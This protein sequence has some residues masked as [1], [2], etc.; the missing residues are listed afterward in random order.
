MFLHKGLEIHER[1]D[2]GVVILE[3][4]GKL[5]MGDGAEAL[6]E[7]AGGLFEQGKR[8]IALDLAKISD[9]DTSGSETLLILAQQYRAAGGKLALFGIDRTHAKIYE[10]ARLESV[11]EIYASA[12]DAV[13][14]FFPD[15][16]VPHYDILDYVEQQPHEHKDAKTP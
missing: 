6:R 16:A 4:H 9:I 12:L 11:I 8:R 3:L 1:E 10:M 15:R 14:S 2:Q 7:F 5:D 13:N